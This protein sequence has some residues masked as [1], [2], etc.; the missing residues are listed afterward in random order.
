MAGV[1]TPRPIAELGEDMPEIFEQF[2]SIAEKLER[3]YRDMQDIELT[4]ER[5]KLYILQTR[6]GKRTA[7]AALKIAH[8]MVGEG[9]FDKKEA[10]LR[11]DPEHLAHVLHRQI[12]SSADLTVLGRRIGGLSGRGVRL[13][14][15]RRQRGRAFGAYRLQGDSGACG[16]DARTTSTASCRHRAS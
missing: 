6:N 14:G 3:H 5:G 16:D 15:V 2:R 9:L 10:L 12:D 4:I 13:R 7:Q 8:D 1:R 11:I